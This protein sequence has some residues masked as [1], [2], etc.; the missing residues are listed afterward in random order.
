M[1]SHGACHS[2][3]FG[4]FCGYSGLVCISAQ[5]PRDSAEKKTDNPGSHWAWLPTVGLLDA[6]YTELPARGADV[7]LDTSGFFP[8]AS[9]LSWLQGPRW[10]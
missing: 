1:K 5:A 9:N 6:S 7:S 3:P 10:G 8:L 4:L 2:H